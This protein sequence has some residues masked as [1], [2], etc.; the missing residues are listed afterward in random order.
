MMSTDFNSDWSWNPG[1]FGSAFED[2][3]VPVA[4]AGFENGDQ[5]FDTVSLRTVGSRFDN[6][7]ESSLGSDSEL[8]G[9]PSSRET[10]KYGFIGGAQKYS[11]ESWVSVMRSRLEIQSFF[12]Q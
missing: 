9:F 5:T 8:N 11:A 6:D 2:V 10:D 4:M 7:G 3:R 12:H 1:A